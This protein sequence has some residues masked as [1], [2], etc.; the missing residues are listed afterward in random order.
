MDL[1]RSFLFVPADSS[2]KLLKARSLLPDALIYDLEDAVSLDKK[3]EAR[4]M[5]AA[6]LPNTAALPVKVFV[7]VNR[8]GTSFLDDDLRAAVRREVYGIV[9]PK[10]GAAEEVA[11][12]D[13]RILRLETK[14]GIPEDSIKLIPILESA[15]GVAHAGE[16]AR[17]SSRILALNFGGE[18]YCAD[19]G[20]SR[21][22]AAE[23]ISFARSFVALAAK[24]EGLG[25]IDGVF[26]DFN[27]AAGLFDETQRIK[28][29]GFTGKTMIHPN[30]IDTVHRAMAP[31]AEE[32]AWAEEVV[33]T[34]KSAGAGVTVVQGK[35]VDEPVVLQARRILKQSGRERARKS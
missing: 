16:L 14:S 15:R 12:V 6:E 7:R 22:K 2:R 27:D 30:Q 26:T 31:S 33:S 8:F 17:S 5:L 32:V 20:I 4:T 1:L 25:A 35:M 29:M 34:F 18:D 24:S 23:E 10:C 13:R 21:T 3:L 28:Q 9:L 11:D 19:M